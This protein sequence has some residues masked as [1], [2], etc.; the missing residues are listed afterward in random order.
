MEPCAPV[1]GRRWDE[2]SFIPAKRPVGAT[3]TARDGGNADFAGAKICF[4]RN[5]V[6]RR[7]F[8]PRWDF[9]RRFYVVLQVS[10]TQTGDIR[11]DKK[12][13]SRCMTALL[14]KILM[15][16]RGSGDTRR[17]CLRRDAGSIAAGTA[18]PATRSRPA[19]PSHSVPLQKGTGCAGSSAA[20]WMA[21]LING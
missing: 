7:P 1:A 5:L 4:R 6:L 3:A 15:I 12:L 18:A 19:R 10:C 14:P 16:S 8:R 9:G 21:C 17:D 20:A 13:S 11:R 2:N